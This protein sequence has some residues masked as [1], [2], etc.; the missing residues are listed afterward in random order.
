[1]CKCAFTTWDL[2]DSINKRRVKLGLDE[3][4]YQNMLMFYRKIQPFLPPDTTIGRSYI[5][6]K[7]KMRRIVAALYK[8]P[9]RKVPRVDWYAW[10]AA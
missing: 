4:S 5:F 10:K 6:R 2:L 8:K 7:G 1:M 3:M 9:Y